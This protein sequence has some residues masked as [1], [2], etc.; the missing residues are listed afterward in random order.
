MA[1]KQE[2]RIYLDEDTCSMLKAADGEQKA[3][4]RLYRKYFPIIASYLVSVNAHRTLIKDVTQE[5]FRRLW[6]H[7][8]RYRPESSFKTYLFSYARNVLLE[9]QKRSAKETKIIRRLSFE[10]QHDSSNVSY[11][12]EY[13][14]Y[15]AAL[16]EK[17]RRAISKLPAKQKQAIRLFHIS[18]GS[19][20]ECAKLAKCSVKSFEGRLYRARERLHR[21]LE[22]SEFRA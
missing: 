21:L 12:P 20:A 8:T 5:V 15:R 6:E 9:E 19:I 18:G 2:K 7:R 13:K 10:Y 22:A 14:A 11:N 16:I 17:A 1:E 3:Y 4:E